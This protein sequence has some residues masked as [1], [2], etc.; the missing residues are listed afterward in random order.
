MTTDQATQTTETKADALAKAGADIEQVVKECGLF[1]L[2][3]QPVFVQTI[4]LAK[5]I[6]QLQSVLTKGVVEA[7]FTPLQNST[8]GF[9][10]DKPDGYGWD[11]VRDCVIEAML[12][13]FR[14]IGNEMNIISGRFYGAKN[15]FERV[16]REYPGLSNLEFDLAV[17]VLA[18]DKGALVG[19]RARWA[20]DGDVMELSGVAPREGE[21]M[22]TRIP[23]KVNGGMGPDAILGKATRKMFF[24]IYNRITGVQVLD[25]EG[26]DV[27]MPP[28]VLP[29]V[30]EAAQDGKRQKPPQNGSAPTNDPKAQGEPG[31]RG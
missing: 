17:P 20:L 19:F 4:T 11:V 13:G 9:L 23:V 2:R 7:Y 29:A 3:N 21:L 14:P 27:P 25:A 30:V 31:E 26:E 18:G 16:V 24:R 1:A 28:K 5:G 10:T 12:R 22:D 6:K 15:G 8:L